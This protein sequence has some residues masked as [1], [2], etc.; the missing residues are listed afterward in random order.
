MER[1]EEM[2]E[3]KGGMEQRGWKGGRVLAVRLSRKISRKEL[4]GAFL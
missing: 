2:R 4:T 3:H 1:R